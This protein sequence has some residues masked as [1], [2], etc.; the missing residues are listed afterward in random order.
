MKKIILTLVFVM[1]AQWN[2]ASVNDSI[3]SQARRYFEEQNYTEA[4][5]SYR[6]FIKSSSD[7]NLKDV[8]VELANSYYKN[9]DK[10]NA[11]NTIKE[12]ITKYGF[13]EADFIYNQTILPKLSDYALSV[14]YDDLE[15][16]HKKYLATLD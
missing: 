6:Q 12:A 16:L 13:V 8:Y 3:L 1:V 7:S 2:F 9:N 14:L 10:K 5:N 15:G 11:V 4:I